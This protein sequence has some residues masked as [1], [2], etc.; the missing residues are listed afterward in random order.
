MKYILFEFHIQIK[1]SMSNSENMKKYKLKVRVYWEY[2]HY[3]KIFVFNSDDV[4]V[5]PSISNIDETI[6]TINKGLYTLRVEINGNI[7]DEVILINKDED[8]EIGGIDNTQYSD[9][10][11]ISLPQQFSSAL[12][13]NS[14]GASYGSS[15]EYYTDPA[16]EWSEKETFALNSIDS[17]K[18]NSS[19]FIFL[20]FPS[21]KRYKSLKKSFS[22]SFFSDFEIVDE[23][24]NC[25]TKFDTD[26]VVVNEQY[27]WVAFNAKLPHGIYYLIY[28]GEE[29]RQV[30]IYVFRYWHTQF[31]MTLGSKPLFG[32]IRTF[33]A[34]HQSFN[35]SE[36]THRYIDILLNKLQNKDYNLDDELIQMAAYGKYES[37]MLGLICSY[38]YLKSEQTK[39]DR[40]FK[41]IIQNMQNVILKEN[42][43]SPDLRA[44][45]IL[46]SN[47]FENHNYEKTTVVGTPMFRVGFEAILK[48]S[49][50][51]SELISQNSD[52]DYISENLLFDSPFITF[53]PIPLTNDRAVSPIFNTRGP[54]VGNVYSTNV[55]DLLGKGLLSFIQNK[56]QSEVSDSWVKNSISDLVIKDE[57][58]SIN[59][60]SNELSISAN[61]VNRIFIEFNNE[62]KEKK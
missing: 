33:V 28:R 13:S 14:E 55:K 44:L 41:A 49:V 62:A 30:P 59:K 37:P 25:I 18:L 21:L 27:G 58:V 31:F 16:V 36:P 47:H 10:K 8:Y 50:E 3:V 53:K 20:R 60:I 23:V 12:L 48:A 1:K 32:T 24:G 11:F 26:E 34:Q 61:T 22:K 2:K 43:E 17:A 39:D 7:K 9:S 54:H 38:I 51:N 56:A 19:L 4:I 35:P 29:Q 5:E 57:N 45:N 40:L 46:A 52:N 42:T 6:F 15:F